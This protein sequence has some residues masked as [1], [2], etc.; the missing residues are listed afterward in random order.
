MTVKEE[1]V[2]DPGPDPVQSSPAESEPPR[3]IRGAH[4]TA[5][6]LAVLVAVLAAY[7][8]LSDG[9]D[10]IHSFG[11]ACRVVHDGWHFHA[12]CGAVSPPSPPG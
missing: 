12:S 11:K 2:W 7:I 4:D 9:I 8:S 3:R 10:Y 1:T 5:I 6:A